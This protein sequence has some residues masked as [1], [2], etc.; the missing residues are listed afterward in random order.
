M[1]EVS[2]VQCKHRQR[3]QHWIPLFRGIESGKL[4][5]GS[6]LDHS[7]FPNYNCD[8]PEDCPCRG[9]QAVGASPPD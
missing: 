8:C 4:I 5:C 9:M 6:D 3:W 2:P 7:L 1:C